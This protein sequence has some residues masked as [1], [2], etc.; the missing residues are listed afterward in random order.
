MKTYFLISISLILLLLFPFS[1][2]FQSLKVSAKVIK[3]IIYKV[4]NIYHSKPIIT[5][6]S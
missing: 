1:V 6:F 3:S 2:L 4:F 5:E